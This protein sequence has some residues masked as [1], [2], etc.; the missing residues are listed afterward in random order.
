MR[1][2]LKCFRDAGTDVA[3]VDSPFALTA[4]GLFSVSIADLRLATDPADAVCP[5][6]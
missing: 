1:V 6:K 3:K 4:T 5:G 2:P